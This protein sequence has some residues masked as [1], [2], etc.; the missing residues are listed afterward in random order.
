MYAA[1]LRPDNPVT[2]VRAAR[3]PRAPEDFGY[4][5]EVELALLFR[6]VPHD[7]KLK[8]LRD[9]GLLGL[10]GVQALRTVEIRRAN[11]TDLQRHGES[12]ALLVH[13]KY[14]DGLIFLRPDIAEAVRAYLAARGTIA[15]DDLGE[16]L[17]VADGNFAPSLGP[18]SQPPRRAPRGRRLPSRGQRH[19]PPG[20]E[21]CAPP[22][23]RYARL[24]TFAEYGALHRFARSR[25]GTVPPG[26]KGAGRPFEI[27][28]FS[29]DIPPSPNRGLAAG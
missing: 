3:D 8:H 23:Q 2:G 19:S 18:P 24:M 7:Y 16:A 28:A 4:L 27:P 12:W 10:L 22:H 5:S 11:V 9:C 29:G 1:G 25:R 13:G 21:P 15:P 6:A 17:I 14:H 26:V 20:V